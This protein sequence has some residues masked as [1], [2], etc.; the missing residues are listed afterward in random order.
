ME[1]E[2]PSRILSF[3]GGSLSSSSTSLSLC[4]ITTSALIV[5]KSIWASFSG[6]SS[7]GSSTPTLSTSCLMPEL[8][9]SEDLEVSSFLKETF[10]SPCSASPSLSSSAFVN[11][12]LVDA[13]TGAGAAPTSSPSDPPSLGFPTSLSSHPNAASTSSTASSTTA[14][15]W[16][17]V[18]VDGQSRGRNRYS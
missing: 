6:L 5:C 18:D 17:C 8:A 16:R 2:D 13:S 3:S 4:T 1:D 15:S 9:P 7:R 14:S 12:M 11:S 10:S